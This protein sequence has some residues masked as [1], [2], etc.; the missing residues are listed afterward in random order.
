MHDQKSFQRHLEIRDGFGKFS[1]VGRG[2]AG[3]PKVDLAQFAQGRQGGESGVADVGAVEVE[4][5]KIGE[6][7][8]VGD[9]SVGHGGVVKIQP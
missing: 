7:F 5:G 3:L 1:G 2:H 8:E 6:G 4:V 9:A